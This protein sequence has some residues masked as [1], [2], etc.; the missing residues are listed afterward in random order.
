[1][2]TEAENITGTVTFDRGDAVEIAGILLLDTDGNEVV[3]G[4]FPSPRKCYR[5]DE[6]TLR[7]VMPT[8]NRLRR[9]KSA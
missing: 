5:G 9:K 6:L 7:I 4:K 3:A 8:V 2:S 1:M